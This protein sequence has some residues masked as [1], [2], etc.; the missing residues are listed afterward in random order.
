ML[1]KYYSS[2]IF[3]IRGYSDLLIY[4]SLFYYFRDIRS[5]QCIKYY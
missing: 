3:R 2:I 4:F 5:L 1:Q